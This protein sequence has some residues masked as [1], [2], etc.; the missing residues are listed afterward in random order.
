MRL[1]IFVAIALTTSSL[2]A[3]TKAEKFRPKSGNAERGTLAGVHSL[4]DHQPTDIE[5][6]GSSF[7]APHFASLHLQAGDSLTLTAVVTD[8]TSD[9][10]TYSGPVDWKDRWGRPLD[11]F[12]VKVTLRN[13]SGHASYD[14]REFAAGFDADELR[15]KNVHVG[16]GGLVQNC[17][18]DDSQPAVC[19]QAT[20]PA[21]F[22]S[23][24]AVVRLIIRGTGGCTG[25]LVGDQGHILTNH[26][27]IATQNDASNTVVE[28][29]A[30]GSTCAEECKQFRAC[31]GHV[32]IEGATFISADKQLDYALIRVQGNTQPFGFLKIRRS[33]PKA[34]ESIYIPQHEHG[35]G[36]RIAF[37]STFDPVTKGSMAAHAP[38]VDSLTSVSCS[39]GS[40]KDAGYFADT[41]HGSSGSPILARSDNLVIALHHCG[42]CLNTATPINAILPRIE[43]A[44][45]ASAFAP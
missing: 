26:H 37:V 5:R 39:S 25:W 15:A 9:A 44:L 21:A 10:V 1:R 36:K 20:Q 31:K 43:A 22:Q 40:L 12:H 6:D 3:A 7:I 11:S 35:W 29:G 45:P 18:P 23:S 4:A 19:F 28:F 34:G 41:E 13:T 17:G 38:T 30:Q 14:I 42:G 33:G 24:N 8:G 16:S 2:V 32:F 27:C